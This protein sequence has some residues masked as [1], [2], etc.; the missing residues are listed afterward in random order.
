MGGFSASA[1][2]ALMKS[3][4]PTGGLAWAAKLNALS[5]PWV[6]SAMGMHR[7][8][9]LQLSITDG[10]CGACMSALATTAR[11]CIGQLGGMV[12]AAWGTEPLVVIWTLMTSPAQPR[13]GSRTIMKMRHMRLT[14]K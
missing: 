5:T 1:V 14:Q 4:P 10:G 12:L 13:K 11:A 7:S 9:A 6:R 8:Q 2:G 3:E